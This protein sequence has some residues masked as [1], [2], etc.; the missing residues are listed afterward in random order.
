M[1][2]SMSAKIRAQIEAEYQAKLVVVQAARAEQEKIAE[3][4]R[5]RK[6]AARK[7]SYRSAARNR[8]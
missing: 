7:A 6:K 2:T 8:R 3:T 4:K 5:K 1:D